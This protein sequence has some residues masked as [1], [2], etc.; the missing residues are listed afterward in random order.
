[1]TQGCSIRPSTSDAMVD[2]AAAQTTRDDASKAARWRARLELTYRREHARSYLARRAHSG[3]LVVQKSLYPE[4]ERVCQTIIVHPPGGIAG[5]DSLAI[6]VAIEPGAHVQFTT[7]GAAKWYRSSGAAARQVVSLEIG[8]EGVLEWLPQEAI[9]FSGAIAEMEAAIDL[10]PT[11]VYVGW[12]IVCLGRTASG[13]RFAAGRL[14]Q[15]LSVRRAHALLFAERIELCG[16]GAELDS[17]VVL[18]G[19]PIFGTLL[20]VA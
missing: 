15:R 4:G 6:E 5:G 19:A 2:A 3:P 7:P 9:V 16:G 20:A 17:P 10:A 13:E 14:S 12:D 8:D 1:M 11:A 18:N